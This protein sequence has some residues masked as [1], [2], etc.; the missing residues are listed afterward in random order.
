LDEKRTKKLMKLV[1]DDEFGQIFI[2]DTDASRIRKIFDEIAQPIRIFD[3]AG[4][5]V[6]V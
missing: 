1:S 6:N 2:T 3:I 4:G 5:Q